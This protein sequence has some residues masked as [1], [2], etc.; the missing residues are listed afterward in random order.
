M[1]WE[2][3]DSLPFQ[4][5]FGIVGAF[6][7][8]RVWN[9]VIVD[10]NCGKRGCL[11]DYIRYGFSLYYGNDKNLEEQRDYG[12]GRVILEKLEDCYVPARLDEL[13]DRIDILVILGHAIGDLESSTSTETWKRLV[14][15]WTPQFLVHEAISDFCELTENIE[16]HAMDVKYDLECRMTLSIDS[17]EFVRSRIFSFYRR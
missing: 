1:A 3:L 17:G 11:K 13:V 7:R 14:E 8:D 4:A 12:N 9:S 16:K 2:Y 10:L 6:L 5:R 15:T